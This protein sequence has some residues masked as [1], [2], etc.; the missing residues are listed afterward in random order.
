MGLLSRQRIPIFKLDIA[1]EPKTE[2]PFQLGVPKLST[3]RGSLP[4][5]LGQYIRLQ[6]CRISRS[7]CDPFNV[8]VVNRMSH[9]QAPVGR[10]SP[11]RS[12]VAGSIWSTN[13]YLRIP[14]LWICDH[15]CLLPGF[16]ADHAGLCEL[17]SASMGR[18]YYTGYCSVCYTWKETLHATCGLH[19]GE[20]GG[21]DW[22]PERELTQSSR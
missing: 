13:Q 7:A 3:R 12:V 21:W 11:S 1:Y 10:T 19:R 20:E 5:Q 6:H 8:H 17:G 16:C 14:L 2:R 9:P 18:G 4:H 22:P 15:L